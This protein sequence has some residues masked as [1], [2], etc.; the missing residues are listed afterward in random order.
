MGSLAEIFFPYKAK[1]SFGAA[2]FALIFLMVLA[3]VEVLVGI[4]LGIVAHRFDLFADL[5]TVILPGACLV[6]L[7]TALVFWWRARSWTKARVE[8]LDLWK[9]GG[10]SFGERLAAKSRPQE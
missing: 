6:A 7:S 9:G 3:E 10:T 8:M 2:S 1:R 4:A 5:Q